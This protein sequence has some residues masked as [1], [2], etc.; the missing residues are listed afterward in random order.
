MEELLQIQ[1]EKERW[2]AVKDAGK[3]T[4]KGEVN[5]IER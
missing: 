3:E 1:M 2:E 4:N 5:K